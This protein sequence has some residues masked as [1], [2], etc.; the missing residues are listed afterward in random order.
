MNRHNQPVTG[1][2]TNISTSGVYF[3]MDIDQEAGSQIE[4]VIDLD[5]PSGPIHLHCIG[6]IVRMEHKDGKR[7]FA[8]RI[9]KSEIKGVNPLSGS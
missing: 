1:I 7:G 6:E 8:T 2:T 4:F 5:T 3:E 9:I